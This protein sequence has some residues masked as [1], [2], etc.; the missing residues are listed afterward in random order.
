MIKHK[1]ASVGSMWSTKNLRDA[2]E[3]THINEHAREGWRLNQ[4]SFGF[5]PWL[6]PTIFRTLERG[7]ADS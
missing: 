1:V 2:G 3:R 5:S 7:E 6:V 4:T